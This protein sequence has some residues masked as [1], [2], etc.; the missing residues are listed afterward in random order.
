MALYYFQI[1]DDLDG[2]SQEPVLAVQIM[3][4]SF[5]VVCYLANEV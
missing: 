1:L 3:N 2:V 4:V 5:L